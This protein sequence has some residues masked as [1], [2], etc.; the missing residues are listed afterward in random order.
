MRALLKFTLCFTCVSFAVGY[1]RTKEVPNLAPSILVDSATDLR[2]SLCNSGSWFQY[3]NHTSDLTGV[4]KEIQDGFKD[5]F[6]IWL[7]TNKPHGPVQFD[8]KSPCMD[9]STAALLCSGMEITYYLKSTS[10]SKFSVHDNRGSLLSIVEKSSA[11]SGDPTWDTL[12]VGDSTQFLTGI[13]ITASINP[14]D[15]LLIDKIVA[16]FA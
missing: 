13:K 6:G 16:H 5:S 14:G 7:L 15:F 12:K 2:R 10:N 11:R 9:F 8:N 3:A 1:H 4:P